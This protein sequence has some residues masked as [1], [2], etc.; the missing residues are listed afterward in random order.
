MYV[1]DGTDSAIVLPIGAAG[2]ETVVRKQ[3]H[4]FRRRMEPFR[5]V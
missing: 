2:T 4:C 3:R 1:G 5:M